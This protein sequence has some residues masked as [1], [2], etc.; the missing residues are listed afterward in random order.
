M[1]KTLHRYETVRQPPATNGHS[2]DAS[3]GAIPIFDT[4]NDDLTH[5]ISHPH[6]P[7]A[8]IERV[9]TPD[10][11]FTQAHEHVPEEP[12]SVAPSPVKIGVGAV[13]ANPMISQDHSAEYAAK[14]AEANAEISRLQ[15]L[16]ARQNENQ[17]AR[18]RTIFSDDGTSVV[19]GLTD[20]GMDDGA[21]V[22]GQA[23]KPDGVPLNVVAM[24]SVLVFVVTYLF[25]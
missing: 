3:A 23:T 15:T 8:D 24:L 9:Q 13:N 5:P 6:H 2:M 1:L 11:H 12:A 17:G 10:H 19:D 20:V 22:I 18:R 21:S 7:P 4:T 25:F 14:L 16:I